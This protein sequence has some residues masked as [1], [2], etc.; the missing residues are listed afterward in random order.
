MPN[1]DYIQSVASDL[2]KRYGTRNPFELC[3]A[4]GVEVFFAD[5]GNLKGMYKYLKRNRFAVI[6][7]NLDDYTRNLVCAH[8]LARKQFAV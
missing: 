8:E 3:R 5:L 1:K 4:T 2:I 7:E 6:N